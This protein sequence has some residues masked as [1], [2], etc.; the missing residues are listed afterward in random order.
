MR[1]AALALIESLV[2]G[3]SACTSASGTVKGGEDTFDTSAASLSCAMPSDSASGITW[4]FLYADFF[5]APLPGPGCKGDGTCHGSASDPGSDASSFTCGDTKEEC[6][7][8]ITSDSAALIDK[9]NPENSKL[10]RTLRHVNAR[11]VKIGTMPKRPEAC[12][13]SEAAL[14]RIE[15]WMAAGAQNN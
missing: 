3:I 4:T 1:L 12:V 2:L 9:V 13:F 14:R 15:E 11:G 8:S 7:A 6:W 5:G 10:V